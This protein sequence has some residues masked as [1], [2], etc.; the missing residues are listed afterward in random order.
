MRSMLIVLGMLVGA[1]AL[2]GGAEV[3][4]IRKVVNLLENLQK[5][6]EEEGAKEKE[7]YDKFMCFCDN[8]ASDLLKAANDAMAQNKA[9]IAQLESDTAEK[10]QLESDIKGHQK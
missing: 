2:R 4:P 7:L 5:E 8:G 9:A 1:S 10:S 6:L 3:N